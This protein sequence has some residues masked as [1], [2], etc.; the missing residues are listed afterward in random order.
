MGSSFRVFWP[1]MVGLVTFAVY[2]IW[3]SV[4][5]QSGDLRDERLKGVSQ[6]VNLVSLYVESEIKTLVSKA[7][8]LLVNELQ[9]PEPT[10]SFQDSD[11]L[12]LALLEPKPEGGWQ[13]GW[14][15]SKVQRVG[16]SYWEYLAEN[17]PIERLDGSLININRVEAPDKSLF[18]AIS[19]KVNLSAPE[20]LGE[21]VAVGLL[22]MSYFSS[23]GAVIRGTGDEIFL[24]D[25]AG[26]SLAYPDHQY[27]G[28]DLRAHSVVRALNQSQ[29]LSH[30]GDYRTLDGESALGSFE[31]V[32][33]TNVY[34][35]GLSVFVS[36]WQAVKAHLIQVIIIAMALSLILFVTAL[37]W[38]RR[39][40]N[41]ENSKLK[42]D[43]KK[44]VLKGIEDQNE[45]SISSESKNLEVKN[46]V[47]QVVAYLKS[48]LMS[49]IGHTHILED[50][51][52]ERAG[53]EKL[54]YIEE[55]SRKSL[56][57]IES[58]GKAYGVEASQ[59][60][61]F[62]LET[63]VHRHYSKVEESLGRKQIA[64]HLDVKTSGR[65]S[66]GENELGQVLDT[67]FDFLIKRSVMATQKK[68]SLEL[69]ESLGQI[70]LRVGDAGPGISLELAKQMFDP[71]VSQNLDLIMAK[72]LV[73]K[74]YG[75]LRVQLS[76]DGGIEFVLV[77]PQ[78][79]NTE[80]LKS[81]DSETEKSLPPLPE[82]EKRPEVT[83]G[84]ES[85]TQEDMD[86]EVTIRKPKVRVDI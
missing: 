52:K 64:C 74:F 14:S 51:I 12:S 55:E 23:L 70:S 67:L 46:L 24:V 62:F 71:A 7:S 72:A 48:P 58:L 45:S 22:P 57:F 43:A 42:L 41:V 39:S 2:A 11:F 34:A 73:E 8:Q 17:L 6:Q 44:E 21:R 84:K 85:V 25:S 15:R 32:N 16:P 61:V 3:G 86:E 56:N 29:F 18:I 4:Q 69:S 65:V 33:N 28:S 66:A 68:I 26:Y 50:S 75:Q 79:Q 81:V 20:P 82:N 60:R 47:A 40:L 1:I 27:V 80:S 49:V 38:V 53:K 77:L 31:K 30:S 36:P 63:L 35:V 9:S 5:T 37:W 83:E 19:Y 10:S 78:A 13:E 59:P 54:Q 76:D